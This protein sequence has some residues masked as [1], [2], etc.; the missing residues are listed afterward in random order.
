MEVGQR[1]ECAILAIHEGRY[2]P[3]GMYIPVE[4]REIKTSSVRVRTLT[5]KQKF[6]WVQTQMLRPI[7]SSGE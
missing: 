3:T 4:I 7:N 6:I 1:M 5:G 2:I